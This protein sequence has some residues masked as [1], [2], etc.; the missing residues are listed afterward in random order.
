MQADERDVMKRY[1]VVGASLCLTLVAATTPGASGQ[2]TV[3]GEAPTNGRIAHVGQVS[4][5]DTPSL[6][7]TSPDG[8]EQSR[9]TGGLH[10]DH[11]SYAQGGAKIVY[12]GALPGDSGPEPPDLY[13]IDTNGTED[14]GHGVQLTDTDAPEFEPDVSPDSQHVVFRRGTGAAARLFIYDAGPDTDLGTEDDTESGP[15]FEPAGEFAVVSNPAFSPDGLWLAWDE[16]SGP[17]RFVNIASFDP[18]TNSTGSRGN[19]ATPTSSSKD[20]D[21]DWGPDG[22][23]IY[24][25]S[26]R[27]GG[28]SEIFSITSG[29]DGDWFERGDN[30]LTNLSDNDDINDTQ[31]AVS[32]EGTKLAFTRGANEFSSCFER[33]CEIFTM[34]TVGEDITKVVG[35]ALQDS[36]PAWGAACES[37]DAEPSPYHDRSIE[38]VLKKHLKAVATV[39]VPDGT[40]PCQHPSVTV[41]KRKDGKWVKVVKIDEPTEIL[42]D[43]DSKYSTS[44]PDKP[45]KYR[46]KIPVEAVP[47]AV[48]DP[49]Y[50]DFCGKDTSPTE[51]HEH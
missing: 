44:I 24:F 45:G 18:E 1:V 23:T 16:G 36:A 35:N 48:E 39:T 20:V 42:S 32:P 12:S 28:D 2:V 41:Q 46:A 30:V 11:P 9:L 14:D 19:V 10:V 8:T 37:C 33:N 49:I 27:R 47:N 6:H 34:T 5:I 3:L 51:T 15:L 26:N 22:T 29:V 40:G 17:N 43:F 13:M 4:A 21:P 25:S 50:D 31:P 38:L 7:T